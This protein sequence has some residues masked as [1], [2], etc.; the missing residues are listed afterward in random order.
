[1]TLLTKEECVA[2]EPSQW[3]TNFEMQDGHCA[4]Q[5]YHFDQREHYKQILLENIIFASTQ[6]L[7]EGLGKMLIVYNFVFCEVVNE[8]R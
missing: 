3:H 1:V 5:S 6:T 8:L 2:G 7:I 4:P